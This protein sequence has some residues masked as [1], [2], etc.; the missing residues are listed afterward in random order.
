MKEARPFK[1]RYRKSRVALASV[2]LQEETS[3]KDSLQP[4]K[5]T[6]KQPLLSGLTLLWQ[7]QY[8]SFDDYLV[9]C[10]YSELAI[11]VR[12]ISGYPCGFHYK[13]AWYKPTDVSRLSWIQSELS[14]LEQNYFQQFT[15]DELL[16]FWKHLQSELTKLD[17]GLKDKFHQLLCDEAP[18]AFFQY[19]RLYLKAF[20]HA[21]PL[22]KEFTASF[23]KAKSPR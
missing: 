1:H 5:Q 16:R 9:A 19:E 18:P 4:T 14:L 2:V 17:R 23:Y 12:K 8:I 7:K 10:R 11:I 20:Q 13:T 6:K 3:P 15:D 21:I 22:I